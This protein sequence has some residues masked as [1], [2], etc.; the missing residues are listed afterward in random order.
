MGPIALFGI[1]YG[2]IVLFH[3]TFTIIYSTFTKKKIQ[4]QQNKRIPNRPLG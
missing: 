1:I 4:V 2:P 3:L